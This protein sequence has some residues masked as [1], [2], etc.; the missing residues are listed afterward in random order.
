MRRFVRSHGSLRAANFPFFQNPI[1]DLALLQDK[2]V[3]KEQ[4][5]EVQGRLMDA[6][7]VRRKKKT[8][9]M[10]QDA[11]VG[12]IIVPSRAKVKDQKSVNWFQVVRGGDVSFCQNCDETLDSIKAGHFLTG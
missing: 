1:L 10:L 6:P 12:T 2:L 11:A 8:K 4:F 7:T 5:R 9:M 3:A